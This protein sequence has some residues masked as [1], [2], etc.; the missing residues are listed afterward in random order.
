MPFWI[1]II[2]AAVAF[3]IS[4]G[5]GFFLIPYLK[6]LNFGQ[7]ILDIGPKWHKDKEGTPTMGGFMFIVGTVLATVVGFVIFN[8]TKKEINL[9][10]TATTLKLLAGIITA[11]FFAMIGFVDDYIK[12][13]K[14]RNLG[15]TS[16]QKLI[17]Q[18][19]VSSLF[20]FVLFVL[21]DRSTSI[22]FPFF[23]AVDF[24]I[25]Y[26]PLMV[27]FITFVVNAVNLTDGIDGL[28]GS[29][30]AICGLSFAL[31][32]VI[33][34]QYEQSIFAMAL[35]GACVGFLVWNLHPAKVFMGD[36]GSMFLGGAF[37]TIG[38]A[39]H[40][41]L[42]LVLIG[43]VY[44]C[45]ALSV[46]IQVISFKT[47]GKRVF[48][49]SPIHHHFEMCKWSEYKIV[50]VFSLVALAAGVGAVAIVVNSMGGIISV[51]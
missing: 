17:L 32:C 23:G 51:K 10:E 49:M 27:L 33:L 4:A 25:F 8:A 2:T 45:E 22:T 47:T 39:T 18:L 13:V 50:I 19:I 3:G 37:V 14:K 30:T 9:D 24:K 46:V 26:Y 16:K 42:L 11:M 43:I 41:H 28:C 6:K 1:N 12:V 40:Q 38:I 15:L 35:A 29:V 21:G 36:T 44:I 7:T 34:S 31:V 48:K 20:L 5:I